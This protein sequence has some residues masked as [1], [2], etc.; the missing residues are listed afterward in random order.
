MP[1]DPVGALAELAA[2]IDRL[3]ERRGD[4]DPQADP[5][6]ATRRLRELLEPRGEAR[7]KA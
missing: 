1:P 6:E 2:R 7:S 4:G 3:A 5:E